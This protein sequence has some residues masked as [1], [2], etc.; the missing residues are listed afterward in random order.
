[1]NIKLNFFLFKFFYEY[2]KN[3]DVC[4]KIIEKKNLKK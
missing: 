4:K 1:M 3:Y 2:I